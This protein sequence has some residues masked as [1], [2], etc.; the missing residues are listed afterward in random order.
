VSLEKGK[1][2]DLV[3]L[4]PDLPTP[5][6]PSS[7]YGHLVNTLGGGDVDTVLVDGQVLLERGRPTKL[8]PARAYGVCREAAEALWVKLSA[9]SS[10]VD[11][12]KSV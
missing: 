8:D 1:K 3:L 7:V 11:F 4:R 6:T 2:A 12:L 9:A 5:L 10:Q